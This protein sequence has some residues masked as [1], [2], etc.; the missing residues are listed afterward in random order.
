MSLGFLEPNIET[1]SETHERGVTSDCVYIVEYRYKG[2]SQLPS[3]A[4]HIKFLKYFSET[5]VTKQEGR[6]F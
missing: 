2:R 6:I 1:G 4:L 3:P 5:D